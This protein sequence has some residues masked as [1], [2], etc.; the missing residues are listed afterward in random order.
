[1][2]QG[3]LS[4]DK[5]QFSYPSR[6]ESAAIANLDLQISAGSNVALVGPSGA[7][8]TTLFDLIMRFYDPQRGNI[9]IDGVDIKSL[10][11]EE[12]RQHIAI[13]PQQP[14]LFSENVRENIRYGR[15]DASD[16]EVEKAAE[17]AFAT[18]FLDRLAEKYD[19]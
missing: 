3:D 5:L 13:V 18:E 6:P 14:A 2:V 16:A 1:M 4:I 17:A 8:K 12:L 15:P 11:P 10:P 19:T 9:A 7:G